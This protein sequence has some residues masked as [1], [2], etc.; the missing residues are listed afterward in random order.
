MMGNFALTLMKEGREKS[1]VHTDVAVLKFL[2][3]KCLSLAFMLVKLF[4]LL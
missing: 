4:I 1:N 2:Q 3:T